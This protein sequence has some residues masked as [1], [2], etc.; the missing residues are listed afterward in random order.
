[1][2]M[3]VLWG[4]RDGGWGQVRYYSPHPCALHRH[5]L[6]RNMYMIPAHHTPSPK[7]FVQ[8]ISFGSWGICIS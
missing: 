6:R 7:K 4:V 1:M 8:T 5:A 2:C 3:R